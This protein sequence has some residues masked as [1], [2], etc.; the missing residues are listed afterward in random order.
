LPDATGFHGVNRRT[1]PESVRS[2]Y[3][4]VYPFGWFGV[5]SETPLVND[6]LIYS[7]HMAS[8]SAPCA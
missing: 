4:R 5:L 8:P 1:I 2:E 6:E 3:E 7:A